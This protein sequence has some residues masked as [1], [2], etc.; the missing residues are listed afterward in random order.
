MRIGEA[1]VF[2]TTSVLLGIIGYK[3]IGWWAPGVIV[4]SYVLGT[5]LNYKSQGRY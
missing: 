5:Y 3:V 1:V 2:L 4:A